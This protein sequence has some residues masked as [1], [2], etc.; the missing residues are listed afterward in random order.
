MKGLLLRMW[1]AL[2]IPVVIAA[3]FYLILTA[4]HPVLAVS[5]MP[6]AAVLIAC[7]PGWLQLWDEKSRFDRWR[8]TLPVSRRGCVDAVYLGLLIP[9][10]VLLLWCAAVLF[11]YNTVEALF[12]LS[13]LTAFS[14]LMPAVFLP[15]AFRFGRPAYAAGMMLEMFLL[16]PAAVMMISLWIFFIPPEGGEI[17]DVIVKCAWY[18]LLPGPAALILFGISRMISVRVFEKKDF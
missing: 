13:F 8:L 3:A 15:F 12:Y 9:T 4:M 6:L 18:E 2:R 16:V 11:R 7:I 5:F 17:G 14:L 10:A 1:Y